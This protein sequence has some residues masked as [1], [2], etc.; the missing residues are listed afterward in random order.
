[1]LFLQR[2]HLVSVLL[3]TEH[4]ISESTGAHHPLRIRRQM[5]FG[6]HPCKLQIL[7][8]L[9]SDNLLRVCGFP[10]VITVYSRFSHSCR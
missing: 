4:K 3:L 2:W 10:N 1:M 6:I 5:G 9:Q 7:L 8:D